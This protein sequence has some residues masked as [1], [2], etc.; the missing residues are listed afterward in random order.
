MEVNSELSEI[1][2]LERI[3]QLYKEKE[4]LDKQWVS[5]FEQLEKDLG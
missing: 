4:K 2:D 3:Q 1:H 5:L